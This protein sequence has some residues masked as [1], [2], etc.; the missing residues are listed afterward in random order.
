MGATG[1][2]TSAPGAGAAEAGGRG[3]VVD[4]SSAAGSVTVSRSSTPWPCAAGLAAVGA[5]GVDRTVECSRLGSSG[6]EAIR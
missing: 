5:E 3:R 4:L 6:G 2:G 1:L